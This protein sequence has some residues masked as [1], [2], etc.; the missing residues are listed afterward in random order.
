MPRPSQRRSR[1]SRRKTAA[2]PEKKSPWKNPPSTASVEAASTPK[3]ETVP[4]ETDQPA[5]SPTLSVGKNFVSKFQSAIARI[6]LATSNTNASWPNWFLPAVGGTLL[7]CVLIFAVRA[8]MHRNDGK[9]LTE[10][11][12]NQPINPPNSESPTT[13]ETPAT[14]S[15]SIE[16]SRTNSPAE[17]GLA[18]NSVEANRSEP[19]TTPMPTVAQYAPV[20][21]SN[22]TGKPARGGPAFGAGHGVRR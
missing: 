21:R 10:V 6:R 4:V 15:Q 13:S 12:A 11:A 17:N 2:A 20:G 9:P 3:N 7:A 5:H 22:R 16:A 18:G 1:P 19:T 14:K 8:V